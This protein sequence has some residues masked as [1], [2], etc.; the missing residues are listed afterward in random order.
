MTIAGDG[1]TKP[2]CDSNGNWKM[3]DT[4]P[5]LEFTYYE[6]ANIAMFNPTYGPSGQLW[7]NNQPG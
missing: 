7:T 5:T 1:N 3:N 2:I 4:L 6:Q